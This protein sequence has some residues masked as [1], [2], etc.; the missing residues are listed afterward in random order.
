MQEILCY[1]QAI[2]REYSLLLLV[3]HMFTR[4]NDIWHAYTHEIF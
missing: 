2:Y 4:K 3:R 1:L